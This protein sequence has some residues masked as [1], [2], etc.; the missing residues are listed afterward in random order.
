ML[1][2]EFLRLADA[3]YPLEDIRKLAGRDFAGRARSEEETK[4]LMTFVKKAPRTMFSPDNEAYLDAKTQYE[5]EWSMDDLKNVKFES[6][7]DFSSQTREQIKITIEDYQKYFDDLLSEN[8]EDDAALHIEV[9][10]ADKGQSFSAELM[11]PARTQK[12]QEKYKWASDITFADQE[13]WYLLSYI[14]AVS[15][16]SSAL[17]VSVAEGVA[18]GKMLTQVFRYTGKL[19]NARF[20]ELFKDF[21]SPSQS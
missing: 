6:V 9:Y 12:E 1:V 3:G 10:S 14:I 5:T 15:D 16:S 2:S 21:F 13:W 7:V 18:R 17:N 8:D 11:S 20:A 4:K 19:L